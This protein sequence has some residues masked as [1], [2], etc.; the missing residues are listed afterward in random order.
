MGYNYLLDPYGWYL[1]LM[2]VGNVTFGD[3]GEGGMVTSGRLGTS[4][5]VTWPINGGAG[6]E[7][8]K[9]ISYKTKCGWKIY[10]WQAI[11]SFFKFGDNFPSKPF[12]ATVFLSIFPIFYCPFELFHQFCSLTNTLTYISIPTGALKLINSL[13]RFQCEWSL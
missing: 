3:G 7:E 13:K 8:V 6:E 5:T 11:R 9:D 2:P 10:L 12:R 1:C 4:V